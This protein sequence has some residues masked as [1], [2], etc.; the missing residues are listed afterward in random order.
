MIKIRESR[1]NPALTC[2]ALRFIPLLDMFIMGGASIFQG[3]HD[4]RKRY[5]WNNSAPEENYLLDF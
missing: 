3:A 5:F 1:H 4:H 2:L